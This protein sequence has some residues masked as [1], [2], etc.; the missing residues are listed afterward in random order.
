M[1]AI[2]ALRPAFK[3][4]VSLAGKRRSGISVK[5][6]HKQAVAEQLAAAI[7]RELPSPQY[8][9]FDDTPETDEEARDEY[10][11]SDEVSP[12]V[13][14][15]EGATIQITV[16]AYERNAEVREACIAH[17][18]TACAVCGFDFSQVYGEL[19]E[20]FTHVH[21][22]RDLATI[23]EEYEVDPIKDL[24]PVCPNCHAMLHREVPAISIRKLKGLMRT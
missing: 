5:K 4:A 9:N 17:Y 21:H 23:G 19:G 12:E 18:G 10:R 20:G 15:R 14:Y 3:E 2:K 8:E 7:G 13:S 24:R 6:G 1:A 22:L 11:S 16:N